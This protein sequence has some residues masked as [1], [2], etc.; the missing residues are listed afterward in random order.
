MSPYPVTPK[1]LVK[2]LAFFAQA[3]ASLCNK[4][5]ITLVFDNYI[6]KFE[7]CFGQKL[8]KI[9]ENCDRNIG[10]CP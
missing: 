10:S 8:A 2:K 3:T 5:I 4:W 7:F 1:N 6:L 9:A